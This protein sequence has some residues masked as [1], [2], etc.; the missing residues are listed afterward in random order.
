[1][2]F[3]PSVIEG[4]QSYS[5]VCYYLFGRKKKTDL[6]VG[7]GSIRCFKVLFIRI[8]MSLLCV[9]SKIVQNHVKVFYQNKKLKTISLLL[10]F[11]VNFLEQKPWLGVISLT[12]VY[13]W[14]SSQWN[15]ISETAFRM[16]QHRK[17]QLSTL[18]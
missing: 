17:Q 2:S 4:E 11:T 13:I 7:V 12:L 1:M 18:P 6:C 14:K 16:M 5:S 3:L 9:Y 10:L 8:Y 15:E